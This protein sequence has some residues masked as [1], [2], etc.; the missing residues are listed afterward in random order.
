[1]RQRIDIGK[2][3]EERI[4]VAM[5]GP[6]IWLMM[7]ICTRLRVCRSSAICWGM[8]QFISP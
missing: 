8:N 5:I 3:Q 7:N 4:G 1:M 6:K 2:E